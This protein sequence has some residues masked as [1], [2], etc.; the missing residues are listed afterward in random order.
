MD[1][2]LK[3][4]LVDNF[5]SMRRMLR[6]LLKSVTYIQCEEVGDGGATLEKLHTKH[7]DVVITDW[8]TPNMTGIESLREIHR[9]PALQ[10]LMVVLISAEVL[11][12][13]I[14]EARDAGANGY[15]CKPFTGNALCAALTRILPGI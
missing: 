12:A 15:I 2:S 1:K 10:Y 11:P 8:N 3:F 9:D 4:L 13:N 7:F 14:V 5:S 6:H